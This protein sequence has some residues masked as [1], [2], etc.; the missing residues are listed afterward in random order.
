MKNPVL[1]IALFTLGAVSSAAAQTPAQMQ[2]CVAIVSSIARLACYDRLA[3]APATA[4]Q[5]APYAPYVPPPSAT[6]YPAAPYYAPPSEQ[7]G[8]EQIHPLGSQG[9]KSLHLAVAS[10]SF[11][12]TGHFIVTL[13]DGE[14]WRQV[15]GDSDKPDLHRK[16]PRS[17]TITRG[18][19]GS[20]NLVFSDQTGRYK[21]D[22]IR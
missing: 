8:A 3:H 1:L 4:S 5:A 16:I 9:P 2:S 20:Y 7:L 13:A 14:V 21:V 19:I 15:E 22:R 6:P 12:P 11:S 18:F 10:V 17:V